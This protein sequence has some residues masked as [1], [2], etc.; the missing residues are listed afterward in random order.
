MAL[1]MALLVGLAL[2]SLGVIV[3]RVARRPLPGRE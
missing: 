3:P 1:M 2:V